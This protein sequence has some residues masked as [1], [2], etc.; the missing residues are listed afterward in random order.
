MKIEITD[1]AVEAVTAARLIPR[2]STNDY[3]YRDNILRDL[4][5]ALPHLKVTE[6]RKYRTCRVDGPGTSW[7]V[8]REGSAWT[9]V[10]LCE[11]PDEA[12][13]IMRVLVIAERGEA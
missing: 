13:H 5:A 8:Q 2:A 1:A 9:N 4:A 10:C 12:E 7:R 6:E 3:G 11:S